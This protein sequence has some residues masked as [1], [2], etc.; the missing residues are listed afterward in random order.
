MSVSLCA[1]KK[2]DIRLERRREP[3]Y[4]VAGRTLLFLLAV[5]PAV[6]RSIFA[7]SRNQP[8]LHGGLVGAGG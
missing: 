4:T 3:S 1:K 5:L 6:L 2:L 7:A 8:R